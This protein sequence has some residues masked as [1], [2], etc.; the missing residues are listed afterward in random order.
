MKTGKRVLSFFFDDYPDMD[1]IVERAYKDSFEAEDITPVRTVGDRHVLELFYGPTL[2]FKDVALQILPYLMTEAKKVA[3]DERNILIL[4][5]TSGDTGKA[6]MEGFKDVPGISI[7]IFYPHGGVSPVQ[8]LQMTTQRG[9][10][11][12]P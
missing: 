7:C 5:A 3:G 4:T 6:A 2:A 12:V 9:P 1:S 11:F 10:M 8:Q